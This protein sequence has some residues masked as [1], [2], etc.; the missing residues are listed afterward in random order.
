MFLLDAFP[1]TVTVGGNEYMVKDMNEQAL[2][3]LSGIQFCDNQIQQLNNEWA[4]ADTA[5][6]AYLHALR[7]ENLK[8]SQGGENG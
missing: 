1:E 3:Q 5:R 8:S 2:A 4:I 6:M 7:S